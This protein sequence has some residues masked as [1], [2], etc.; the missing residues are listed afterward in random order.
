MP[1]LRGEEE[2]LD[3][4]AFSCMQPNSPER[5]SSAGAGSSGEGRKL[6]RA[7]PFYPQPTPALHED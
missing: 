1:P 4:R 6:Y 3:H 2:V 5:F 7:A